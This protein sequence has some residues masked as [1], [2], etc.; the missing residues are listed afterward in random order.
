MSGPASEGGTLQESAVV[1]QE[2]QLVVDAL[3]DRRAKDIVVLD[4]TEVSATLDYF[5]IATGESH[6]QLRALE[7]AVRER[8]KLH[9][10]P[11]RGVEGPSHRW[12]LIDYGDVVA[13]I[14]QAEVRAHYDLERLWSEAPALDLSALGVDLPP[15]TSAGPST[16]GPGRKLPRTSQ[17]N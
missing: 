12:V 8:L 15:E 14:F 6:L 7:D 17:A 4:L 5:I 1:P 13:H 3:D 2:V 16:D 10:F 11:P 9:G